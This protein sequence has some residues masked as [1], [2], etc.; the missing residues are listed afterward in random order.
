VCADKV[1]IIYVLLVHIL[2]NVIDMYIRATTKLYE[3]HL[4]WYQEPISTLDSLNYHHAVDSN[5]LQ[6]WKSIG[7]KLSSFFE[8]NP[9]INPAHDLRPYIVDLWNKMKGGQDY[10]S[11]QLCNTKIDFRQLSPRAFLFIRQIKTQ[12]LNAHTV[13]RLL[14][15]KLS[16]NM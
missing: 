6:L 5:T 4:K 2:D 9:E 7:D 14:M 10:V 16:V 8:E 3:L 13:Y 11:R 12:L 15:L 1:S